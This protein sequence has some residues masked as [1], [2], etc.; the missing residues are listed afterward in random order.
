ME[1]KLISAAAVRDLCGGVSDMT[2]WRWLNDP[3]LDFPKPVYIGRRR[4]WREADM[5]GWLKARADE[6]AA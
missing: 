1:H 6:A 2:I 5:A 4:Y 3:D